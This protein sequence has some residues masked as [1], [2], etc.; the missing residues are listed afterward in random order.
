[1]D[2]GRISWLKSQNLRGRLTHLGRCSEDREALVAYGGECRVVRTYSSWREA[3]D[4]GSQEQKRERELREKREWLTATSDLQLSYTSS[5]QGSP[6]PN[7]DSF[8]AESSRIVEGPSQG[9]GVRCRPRR[10]PYPKCPLQVQKYS[11]TLLPAQP[12]PSY[13]E[14]LDDVK[15]L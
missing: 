11:S 12:H 13:P 1:M 3:G 15:K 9:S 6:S 7:L 14:V 5:L 10:K 2:L 4:G 8:L